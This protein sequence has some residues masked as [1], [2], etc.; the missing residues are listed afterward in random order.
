MRDLLRFG[1]SNVGSR[2]V[3]FFFT[4]VDNLVVGRQLGATALGF[5]SKAFDFTTKTVDNINK[6]IGIVLFPSYARIQHERD[7]LSAAYLTS[8]RMISSVTVP[9]AMGIF[10]T[11]PELVPVVLGSKW[12]PMVPILQILAFMSLVKPLSSTTSALFNAMGRPGYNLRAGLVVSAVLVPLMFALLGMG[13][14]GVAMAVF[15]A[16]VAGFAYNVYQVHTLLPGTA[17]RMLKTVLPALGSAAVMVLGIWISKQPLAAVT[18]AQLHPL[19]LAGMILVGIGVYG[20]MIYLFQRDL[21]VEVR[22]LLMHRR[23]AGNA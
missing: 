1:M 7:R 11:A 23:E 15:A 10:I 18:G 20:A 5:Y 13:P 17:P 4:N 6:T 19:T 21:V 22:G 2:S 9:L 16:H 8:L 3:Y 14:E 12:V